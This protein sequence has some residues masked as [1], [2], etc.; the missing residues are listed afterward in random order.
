MQKPGQPKKQVSRLADTNPIPL[1][2]MLSPAR[3]AANLANAQKS[4]GPATD[5]GKQASSLNRTDHGLTAKHSLLPGENPD[6]Y[7]TFRERML[8]ETKAEGPTEEILADRIVDCAWRLR[9]LGRIEAEAFRFLYDQD[10]VGR[11]EQRAGRVPRPTTRLG[12]NVHYAATHGVSLK[13]LHRYEVQLE[14]SLYEAITQL[15]QLQSTR[16]SLNESPD[17]K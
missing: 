4:T 1:K 7:L 15:R 13:N 6:E 3:L 10:L 8:R 9:R 16:A 17:F 12:A 14:R 2:S 5:L 11:I